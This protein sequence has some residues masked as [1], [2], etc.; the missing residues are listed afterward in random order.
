MTIVGYDIS[1]FQE[2]PSF[3]TAFRSG[4]I[5]AILKATQGVTYTDPKFLSFLKRLRSI[6]DQLIGAY[7][8]GDD[9]DGE[10][11]AQHFMAVA[12]GVPLLALDWE[13]NP[14]GGTMS[15]AGAEHFVQAVQAKTGKWPLLYGGSLL[16]ETA[17]PADSPLLKCELWIA[18]YADAP[19]LPS[20]W[21]KWRLWQSSGDGEG[22]E[23]HDVPGVGTNI[24]VNRFPGTPDDCRRWYE[25]LKA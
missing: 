21:A 17:I 11:Q 1:H 22:P 13:N 4:F 2:P 14:G 19:V 18:Q 15:R 25:D 5:L 23:P 9:S 20:G 8:F 7:H 12:N 3:W 6:P 24:D 10:A 16:K